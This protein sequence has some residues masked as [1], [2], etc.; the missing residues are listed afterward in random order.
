MT[1]VKKE[2]ET[3]TL[4]SEAKVRCFDVDPNTVVKVIRGTQEQVI[5]NRKQIRITPGSIVTFTK[6]FAE[7][8]LTYRDFKV[9]G[10]AGAV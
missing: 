5:L 7:F 4:I 10:L 9:Y 8:L 3:M 2:V 1:E 6:K